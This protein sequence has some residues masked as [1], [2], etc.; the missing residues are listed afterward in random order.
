MLVVAVLSKYCCARKRTQTFPSVVSVGH[1]RRLAALL[2]TWGQRHNKI[3]PV[4]IVPIYQHNIPADKVV[5]V[6][7][8]DMKYS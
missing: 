5:P 8:T 6:P 1:L 7:S 3:T 4:C 2:W